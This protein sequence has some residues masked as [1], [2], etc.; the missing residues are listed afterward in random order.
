[1]CRKAETENSLMVADAWGRG[2]KSWGWEESLLI[3]NGVFL[4]GPED[5]QSLDSD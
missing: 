1:M 4:F 2:E 5:D 3:Y